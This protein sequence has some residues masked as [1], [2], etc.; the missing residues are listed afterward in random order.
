M[1]DKL[2]Q[3]CN[4]GES[5]DG[6]YQREYENKTL[7]HRKYVDRNSFVLESKSFVFFD[8]ETTNLNAS[9]GRI[10]CASM[11]VR[12]YSD[13]DRDGTMKTY[14]DR[15]T[16][17]KIAVKIRDFIERF[18]YVVTYYGTGFDIPFINTRL[19]IHGERPLKAI[20]HIDLYY[21]AR[22]VLKLHSNRLAVVGET[23]F[24]ESGKTK[25]M[26]PIWDAAA[27]GDKA[28]MK[29]IVEHCEA[30]VMELEK[31]FDVLKSFRNLGATPLKGNYGSANL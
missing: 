7:I 12:D 28:S 16:D 31:V 23:L 15:K 2:E 4:D 3:V 1:E 21:T 6:L 18:D 8:I 14:V 13:W 24:G 27:S 9:I 22:N 19:L 20:R 30:D 29:Y 10:L 25:L 26:G 11:L 5:S 17:K